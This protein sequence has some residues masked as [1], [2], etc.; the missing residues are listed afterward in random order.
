MIYGFPDAALIGNGLF[1]ES[2][3]NAEQL[4]IE[5]NIETLITSG[6]YDAGD[7]GQA[8][9]IR[10][11]GPESGSFTSLDG[12]EWGLSEQVLNVKMFGARGVGLAYDD[13]TAF[14][15][16]F[17]TG[18][19]ITIP[20]CE[21]FYNIGSPIAVSANGQTITG[22][23]DGIVVNRGTNSDANCFVGSN[24][25]NI[26]FDGVCCTPGTTIVSLSDGWGF[27]NVG[28]DGWSIRNCTVTRM[29]RGGVYLLNA[30]KCNV[31]N[32]FFT[33]SVVIGDGTEPQ[34]D[35][36]YDI[37]IG[38]DS[39]INII[40]NNECISGC[41]T[42]IGLQTDSTGV[43]ITHTLISNNICYNQPCYGIMMYI[44][45]INDNDNINRISVVDN[46]V[47]NIS[48]AVYIPALPDSVFYGAGIYIQ[49]VSKIT[50]VGNTVSKTNTYRAH[51]FINGV[52]AAI[53]I[54]GLGQ[55]ICSGNMIDDCYIGIQSTQTTVA[56][57]EEDVTII[58]ANNIV[59]FDKTGIALVDCY[60]ASVTSNVL[61]GRPSDPLPDRGVFI[62]YVD[63][64]NKR[65]DISNNNI[66]NVL[67]G[68]ETT[69][70]SIEHLQANEN[71]IYNYSN[72]GII[73]T[74]VKSYFNRN[75]IEG[76][77]YGIRC[78]SNVASGFVTYNDVSATNCL[79]VYNSGVRYDE[80]IVVGAVAYATAEKQVIAAGAT[81][82][83]KNGRWYTKDDTSTL[84][85]ILGAYRLQTINIQAKAAFNISHGLGI[86]TPT[87]ASFPIT[88]GDQIQLQY[89][90]GL[91]R[92][93]GYV[94]Y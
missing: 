40:S 47:Y 19:N 57:P 56:L 60:S 24:F 15:D 14:D 31:S 64:L 92:F 73:S 76:G 43:D 78:T 58:N 94:N 2:R 71:Y 91:W 48:G 9:Y 45:D 65:F 46:I 33:D 83:I 87:G 52:P 63:A 16:A 80:N 85:N 10:V 53:S 6:Y 7:G 17:G 82:T 88:G 8:Y 41:G 20:S 55:I 35:M 32:N 68:I 49:T 29:R 54:S 12:Q 30:N 59:N 39:A 75:I 37:Y 86:Q 50:L 34:S 77:L 84:E 70:N 72:F 4:L 27:L 51:P 5:A 69:G 67:A 26:V 89:S 62:Q 11:A 36:G 79:D 13:T 25:D 38:G 22:T 93:I 66:S 74:A 61:R 1:I 81:P 23:V 28:G 21:T 90:E 18:K 44:F 42:G 3:A